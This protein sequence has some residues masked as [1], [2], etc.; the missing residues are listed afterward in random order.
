MELNIAFSTIFYIAVFILPG[1]IFRRIYFSGDHNKQFSQ[2][3]LVERIAWTIF[4]SAITLITA[5]VF[6]Y[7][8][9]DYF[10]LEILTEFNYAHLQS[11]FNQIAENKFPSK[12]T[13]TD[14][15]PTFI[16]GLLVFY[17]YCFLLA[18]LLR[19]IVLYCGFDRVF[20]FL[21]F[22]NYW[23]YYLQGKSPKFKRSLV[24]K[25]WASQ[26]DVLV[27]VSDT[28]TKL[29]KGFVLDYFIDSSTNQLDIIFLKEAQRFR[30]NKGNNTVDLVDIPGTTLGIPFQ[31]VLNINLTYIYRDD[32]ISEKSKQ[33]LKK[34]SGLIF[35]TLFALSIMLL[36]VEEWPV[37]GRIEIFYRVLFFINTF[38]FA[39][40]MVTWINNLIKEGDG[41]GVGYA[42]AMLFLQYAWIFEILPF[43]IVIPITLVA[44]Y[45]I[46]VFGRNYQTRT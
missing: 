14:V 18:K 29:Y 45:I 28:E 23:Y 12:E 17:I 35:M 33:R 24:K 30:T 22:N 4:S 10:N 39:S 19:Q 31:K 32:L 27:Q 25:F 20:N 9:D 16:I 13:L 6:L 38:L 2:G 36:F 42:V 5:V 1:L 8:I 15:Y 3:N 7:F 41:Q 37:V 46:I 21:R 43:Y 26:A 40:V 11:I 34:V 44:S